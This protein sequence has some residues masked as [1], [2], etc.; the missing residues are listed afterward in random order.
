MA[1]PVVT[2][3]GGG[4]SGLSAA[5]YLSRLAPQISIRLLEASDRVG[6]WIK[7][8]HVKDNVLFEAGPR[9]LRPQGVGGALLLDMIK[10]L[11]LDRHVLA[12]PKTHPSAQHRYI[13][14][15]G[16]INQLPSGL[17]DLIK[18]S[19]P[20]MSSV[21]GSILKEPF[22]T[23]QGKRDETIYDFIERRFN[24][25]VALTLIGALTHGIY[26]GDCKTLSVQ[27]TFPL[28][29]ACEDRHGSVVKGMLKGGVELDTEKEQQLASLCR[30]RY[31]EWQQEM[32]QASVIG[33][34][35][36]LESLPRAL[37]SYLLNQPN[38]D[39]LTNQ[40]ANR[41]ESS[42]P[43]SMTITTNQGQ[44]E[45]N[46]VISALPSHTLASLLPT[47]LPHLTSNPSVDVAVVNLAYKKTECD[48]G[49]D[50]FGFLTPH[51]D[52]PYRNKVP[53]LLGVIF[54]SNSMGQQDEA[55]DVVR[56]TAMIGGSD[57]DLAF[58]GKKDVAGHALALA[59][60]AM[61]TCLGVHA[62]P[63]HSRAHVL[64]QCLPQYRVGHRLGLRQLHSALQQQW[65]GR[66]SVVGSSY[67]GV[68]VPDCVKHSRLLVDD[69][70]SVGDLGS[71]S[72]KITGLEKCMME[73]W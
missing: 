18:N 66:L 22:K 39:L 24:R 73:P 71:Q 36:G 72:V 53:G 3:L 16:H 44:Y 27:S 60:Q 64:R 10:E 5:Y 46:H 50:G 25:H 19:P 35:P 55:N 57:W 1:Q 52:A 26:A 33:L 37:R 20:I 42:S 61:G 56:F 29:A 14:Y 2:I 28:L 63:V 11:D 34:L 58:D 47:A 6:G 54:D 49:L 13:E 4:I 12:V 62:T 8:E 32:Q 67:L 65:G 43:T 30:S 23:P 15:Q 31:P 38:V 21:I 69:L 48:T 17:P 41:L 68:S 9:T 45:S 40:V 51:R 59:Q 7:S 70:V